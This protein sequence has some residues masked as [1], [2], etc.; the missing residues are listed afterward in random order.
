MSRVKRRIVAPVC[1]NMIN[2]LSGQGH[3]VTLLRGLTDDRAVTALTTPRPAALLHTNGNEGLETIIYEG[4]S[5]TSTLM[6]SV[7][8]LQKQKRLGLLLG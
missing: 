6:Q 1:E 5:I 7:I 3:S 8:I 2:P 4:R